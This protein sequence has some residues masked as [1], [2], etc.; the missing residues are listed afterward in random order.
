MYVFVHVVAIIIVVV[1]VIVIV[2]VIVVIGWHVVG[3]ATG[4]RPGAG[5]GTADLGDQLTLSG[6]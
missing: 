2:I 5:S 6:R 1:V 4:H 3:A